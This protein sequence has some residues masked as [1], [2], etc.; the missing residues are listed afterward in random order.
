MIP[1]ETTGGGEA[2]AERTDKPNELEFNP[3]TV[4]N[5]V[6]SG[7]HPLLHGHAYIFYFL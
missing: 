5:K 1:Q 4:T 7:K 6:D 2:G 3:V